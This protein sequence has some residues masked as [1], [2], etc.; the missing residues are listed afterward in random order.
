MKFVVLFVALAVLVAKSLWKSKKIIND[1][2]HI[3]SN[4]LFYVEGFA[5]ECYICDSD[6][7]ANCHN[8]YDRNVRTEVSV[9]WVA[10][11]LIGCH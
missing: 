9:K 8:M 10:L 4:C 1:C 11:K 7:D 3:N 6:F 5:L 2:D